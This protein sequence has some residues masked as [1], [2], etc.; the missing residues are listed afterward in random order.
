MRYILIFVV[1]LFGCESTEP[2]AESIGTVVLKGPLGLIE[3]DVY[4]FKYKEHQYIQFGETNA[5]AIVH[6]PDCKK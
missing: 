4:H 5:R 3:T 1:L 2:P 6:D